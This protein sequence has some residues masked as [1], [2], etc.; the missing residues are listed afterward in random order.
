M[1]GRITILLAAANLTFMLCCKSSRA[2]EYYLEDIIMKKNQ[3]QAPEMAKK[4]S[5][6][7]QEILEQYAAQTA[8]QEDVHF[9]HSDWVYS[10]TSCCC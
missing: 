7:K 2:D 1:T 5:S 8:D 9:Y 10:D 3:A 6:N 4:E